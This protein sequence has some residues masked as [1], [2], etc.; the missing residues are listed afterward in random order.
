[1][2]ASVAWWPFQGVSTFTRPTEAAPKHLDA[3]IPGSASDKSRADLAAVPPLALP[4]SPV[5]GDESHQDPLE[6]RVGSG[7]T[8]HTL[9]ID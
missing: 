4:L 7:R 6:S 5:S 1:M 8:I 2:D 9:L 3:L